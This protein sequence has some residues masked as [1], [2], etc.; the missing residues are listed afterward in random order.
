MYFLALI[1]GLT[2]ERVLAHLLHLRNHGLLA[3]TTCWMLDRGSRYLPSAWLVLVLVLA[4]L[5][6]PVAGS[7]WAMGDT[8]LGMPG[9]VFSVVV[10]VYALG[11][12]DLESQVDAYLAALNQGDAAEADRIGAELLEAELPE[13]RV[14]RTR[15]LTEA[16]LVQANN[17]VFSIVFWFALLGPAGAWAMRVT[18]LARHRLTEDAAGSPMALA[19]GTLHGVLAWAPSRLVALGYALAGSFQ[20]A[21]ADWRTLYQTYT[22]HFLEVNNEVV[23]CAGWGALGPVIEHDEARR[24]RQALSLVTRTLVIWLVTIGLLTLSGVLV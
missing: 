10:L 3:D 7:A 11:P 6:A 23:A 12:D 22:G 15:A 5:V 14:A 8:L 18:D 2:V 24:V 4:L 20:D 21:F 17:R 16:I 13:E 1:L 19:A 9:L